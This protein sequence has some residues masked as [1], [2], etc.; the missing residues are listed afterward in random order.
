MKQALAC[1][2][3]TLYMRRLSLHICFIHRL[4]SHCCYSVLARGTTLHITSTLLSKFFLFFFFD[5]YTWKEHADS[6]MSVTAESRTVEKQFTTSTWLSV[7]KQVI[8]FLST[9]S[10]I[11]TVASESFHNFENAS[12]F[13]AWRW[14]EWHHHTDRATDRGM[15]ILIWQLSCSQ[16]FLA[17][18]AMRLRAVCMVISCAHLSRILDTGML[19]LGQHYSITVPTSDGYLTMQNR[20]IG[21]G[22]QVQTV[23]VLFLSAFQKTS[24]GIVRWHIYTT[25]PENHCRPWAVL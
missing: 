17:H 12:P 9:I 18:S 15:L 21:Y 2:H 1:V 14:E 19:S 16:S 20:Q 22:K 3:A 8:V 6:E 11:Y 10:Y 13:T 24:E 7:H 5:R 23:C 4:W 25:P